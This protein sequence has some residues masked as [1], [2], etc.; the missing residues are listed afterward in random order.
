MAT[1][2]G[3]SSC[4][5]QEI[6][7]WLINKASGGDDHQWQNDR[8][9]T[10]VTRATFRYDELDQNR[11]QN[12]ASPEVRYIAGMTATDFTVTIQA[13]TDPEDAAGY[14]AYADL[15][16]YCRRTEIF[17]C[18]FTDPGGFSRTKNMVITK[19]AAQ[20]PIDGI[21]VAEITLKVAA[22]ACGDTFD[23]STSGSGSGSGSGS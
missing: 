9:L 18:T 11:S 14:D 6:T 12:A 20:S 1:T 3:L 22:G 8:L 17:T 2:I 7:R 4:T 13:G 21:N 5:T 16:G 19:W 15:E 10:V 23:G